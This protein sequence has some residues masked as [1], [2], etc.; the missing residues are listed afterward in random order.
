MCTDR[1]S[2]VSRSY[3]RPFSHS[4]FDRLLAVLIESLHGNDVRR[5][6]VTG[7]FYGSAHKS[8]AYLRVERNEFGA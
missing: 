1:V 2:L 3:R 4:Q 6:L 8:N 7:P 5:T